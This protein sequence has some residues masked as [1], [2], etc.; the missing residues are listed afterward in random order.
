MSLP[1]RNRPLDVGTVVGTAGA[2]FRLFS[3]RGGRGADRGPRVDFRSGGCAG[4][5]GDEH[6]RFTGAAK[7]ERKRASKQCASY[8]F[9]GSKHKLQRYAKRQCFISSPGT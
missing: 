5:A 8:P 2:C 6:E 7:H 1:P 9:T 4:H 3:A